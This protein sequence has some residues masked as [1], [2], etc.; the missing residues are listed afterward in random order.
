MRPIELDACQYMVK[1]YKEALGKATSEQLEGLHKA[2]CPVCKIE[3]F[4]DKIYVEYPKWFKYLCTNCLAEIN[5][6][7]LK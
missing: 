1:Y 5:V 2:I 3:S 6:D 7:S 4:F